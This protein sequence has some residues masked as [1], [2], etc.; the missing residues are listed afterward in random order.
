M[1]G[2]I[3]TVKIIINIEEIT[4]TEFAST[5]SI[6]TKTEAISNQISE[7]IDNIPINQITDNIGTCSNTQMTEDIKFVSITANISN[8][9]SN[10][11]L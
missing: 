8:S 9:E 5:T 1:Q 6:K 2:S 4:I 7:H 3:T 10:Q 11:I